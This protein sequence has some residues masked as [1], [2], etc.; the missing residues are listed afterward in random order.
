MVTDSPEASAALALEK[1]CDLNCGSAYVYM[2]KAYEKGM[3]TEEQIRRSA[4]RLFTCR[5]MLGLMDDPDQKEMP[6][7][8]GHAAHR[9]AYDGI[10]LEV[11][12]CPEHLGKAR[13]ASEEACVLLK[14]DGMLPLDGDRLTT[15]AVIGPNANSRVALVGN[16]HGTSSRYV[17]V[18]EGLQDALE[19]KARVLYSEGCHL[20]KD[21]VEHL[22]QPGDRLSE[23]VAVA[24][25]ADAVVLVVGLDETL[26]GEEGDTGNAAASGD[27][28]DLL[29]PECQ[30]RLMD[31]VLAVGRPTVI[32]LMAGSAIDLGEAAEKADAVLLT[33]YPGARGGRSVAD[34]LLG[35]VSPSGK[36]P[37]TFYKNEQLA[38]MP[39]FTDYA[40]KGR[41]YRYIE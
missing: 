34:I 30:R 14:N 39:E 11:V 41:T 9:S 6:S 3:V 18:L 5:Y 7:C 17:T 31:A 13:K 25:R 15:L 10:P 35:K 4:V 2:M 33:W 26:E 8:E 12:E 23:A 21:R 27:K 1:G 37:V 19:G 40:M 28:L 29:L 22:G 38:R 32:V 16:Y 36:L 20:F 24:E